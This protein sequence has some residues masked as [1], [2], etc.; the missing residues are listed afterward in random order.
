MTTLNEIIGIQESINNVS[1]QLN[2]LRRISTEV[3]DVN[4]LAAANIEVNRISKAIAK[5]GEVI[6]Q[7]NKGE[8]LLNEEVQKGINVVGRMGDKFK[9]IAAN[10]SIK[11]IA[12]GV[13]DTVDRFNTQAQAEIKLQAVVERDMK[14]N[15]IQNVL[16]TTKLEQQKG[17]IADEVQLDG[18]SQLGSYVQST[19]ALAQLIPAMN[20]LAVKQNGVSA[21]SEQVAAAGNMIGLAMRGQTGELESVGL[22]FTQA[23]REMMQYGSEAEKVAILSE[24][25]KGQI[26]SVNEEAANT[27]QGRIQQIQNA[28]NGIKETVGGQ[29]YPRVLELL[30]SV[31]NHLPKIQPVITTIG[32]VLA[33]VI[34][35]VTRIIDLI[36]IVAGII[37]EGWPMIEPIIWGIVGALAAYLMILGIYQAITILAAVKEGFL[38]VVKGISSVMTERCSMAIFKQTLAQQGLNAALFA[39]PLTWIILLII[40]LI[41]IVYAVVAAINHFAGTSISAT[42][43]I[44][45]AFMVVLATIGNV[46]I[47]VVNVIIDAF[48]GIYNLVA[49]VAEFLANVFNDPIGAIV[50]LFAGL[51]DTVFSILQTIASGIDTVFGSNLADTVAGWRSSL[52]DSVTDL[53]GEARIKIPRIEAPDLHLDRFE[54]GDAWDSGYKFGEGID[55]KVASFEM[56]QIPGLEGLPTAEDASNTAASTN[57]IA[58]NTGQINDSIGTTTEDLTYLRDLAEVEAINRFTTAQIKVDM[59]NNNTINSALDIDGITNALASKVEEQMA[60]SAEGVHY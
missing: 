13:M 54:Y 34:G 38:A 60:I 57:Q 32:N 49:L 46:I 15:D 40:A 19:D 21:T 50:R 9:N 1:N 8:Q 22:T 29:L 6:Q 59:K 17:V 16:D 23:Q 47:A 53:V 44:C 30:T 12:K 36:G 48:V 24:I 7:L 20:D 58:E 42:G 18:A 10:I 55:Q 41:V 39:C 4:N 52:K 11:D 31:G 3:I 5:A 25:V 26:G 37:S 2:M 43:V 14:T 27:P 51:A 56:P 45:G 35:F 33:V 28:L